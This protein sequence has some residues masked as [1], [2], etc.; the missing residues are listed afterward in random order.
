MFGQILLAIVLIGCTGGF[1]AHGVARAVESTGNRRATRGGTIRRRGE[2]FNA[3]AHPSPRHIRA[4]ARAE[5]HRLWE[6]ARSTDW[7]ERQRHEREQAP[8][9]GGDGAAPGPGPARDGLGPNHPDYVPG[10]EANPH[11][12]IR[13]GAVKEIGRAHV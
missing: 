11:G 9:A 2:A 13:R 4:A 12:R 10:H 7:L 8:R 6:T 5:A 1:L 3:I